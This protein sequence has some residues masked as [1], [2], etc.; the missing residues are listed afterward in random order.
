METTIQDVLDQEPVSVLVGYDAARVLIGLFQSLDGSPY[1]EAIQ[2]DGAAKK[3]GAFAVEMKARRQYDVRRSSSVYVV[4]YLGEPIAI[5]CRWGREESDGERCYWLDTVRASQALGA[6][7]VLCV[8]WP[9]PSLPA[10]PVEVGNW[11]DRPPRLG[12]SRWLDG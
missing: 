9:S 6:L 4:R 12:E 5:A 7:A 10:A 8:E 2:W 3:L 11:G 1:I